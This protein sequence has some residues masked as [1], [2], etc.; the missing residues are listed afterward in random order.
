MITRAA[1]MSLSCATSRKLPVNTNSK[2]GLPS[3][4][5]AQPEPAPPGRTQPNAAAAA[6]NTSPNKTRAG[7][8]H[9][10]TGG[11]AGSCT[12]K[13]ARVCHPR[14]CAPAHVPRQPE[15]S[16]VA[17]GLHDGQVL[18]EHVIL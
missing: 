8:Q 2:R 14:V 18:V 5:R 9:S 15:Q 17:Q 12:V 3:G 6:S 11:G 4:W 13:P 16:R 10:K 7:G 1:G